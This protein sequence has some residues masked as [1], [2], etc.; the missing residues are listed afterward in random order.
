MGNLGREGQDMAI[1]PSELL[2]DATSGLGEII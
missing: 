1:Y 2:S